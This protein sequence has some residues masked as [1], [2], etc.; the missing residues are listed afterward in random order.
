MKVINKQMKTRNNK[1][2]HEN[3]EKGEEE[4]RQ[5]KEDKIK[6]N[7]KKSSDKSDKDVERPRRGTPKEILTIGQNPR[8]D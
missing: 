2:F 7:E 4:G 1:N 6:Q 5:N 8:N 3:K